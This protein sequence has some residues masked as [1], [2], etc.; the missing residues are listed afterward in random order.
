LLFLYLGAITIQEKEDRPWS[1]L[2]ILWQRFVVLEKI[3]ILV[4]SPHCPPNLSLFPLTSIPIPIAKAKPVQKK[5]IEPPSI[6]VA[7]SFGD[8]KDRADKLSD[9]IMLN[10][11]R[12]GWSIQGG[13]K[14]DS[15]LLIEQ[16]PATPADY[17][18]WIKRRSDY[19]RARF[20]EKVLDMRNEFTELHYRNEQ[21]DDLLKK[22]AMLNVVNEKLVLMGQ[23]DTFPMTP[24]DISE[25][26]D[27]LKAL[28]S[29][30]K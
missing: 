17:P 20:Y 5:P 10:L 15:S 19:F 12:H 26:A 14:I 23:K 27:R 7:P 4:E 9:E 1:N 6:V 25:V 28:A 21:L 18:A 24:Y 3:S 16:F 2:S 29:K 30:I 11:Y 13:Q 22:Q 8:L